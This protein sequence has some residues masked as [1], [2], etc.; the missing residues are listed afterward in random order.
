MSKVPAY[1][2]A[3]YKLFGL[4]GGE[5]IDTVRDRFRAEIKKVH[6]DTAGND[7]ETVKRLQQLLKAYELLQKFAPRRIE[8]VISPEEARKGGLRTIKL[9]DRE[10]MIRLPIGVKNGTVLAPIGDSHWRVLI[11][12]RDEMVNPDLNATEAEIQKR[13]EL[14]AKFEEQKAREA[15]LEEAEKNAGIFKAF[16]DKFVKASPAARFAKWA[17]RDSA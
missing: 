7:P 11:L 17:R 13:K 3:A 2:K 8:H 16:Y 6:P 1:I 15:A 10:A 9:Q 14:K 5:D 12:V 4:K